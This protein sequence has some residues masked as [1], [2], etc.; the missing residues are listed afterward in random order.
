MQVI[1]ASRKL[2]LAV[3]T[4]V[5]TV[6]LA[7]LEAKIALKMPWWRVPTQTIA[8]WASSMVLIFLPLGAWMLQ[9]RR[10]ALALT[11]HM[12]SL[13]CLL[14]VFLGLNTQ[15]PSLFFFI[16]L[17]VGYWLVMLQWLRLEM[18]R[19]FFNPRTRW[20]EGL[21][22]AIAA[23]KCQLAQGEHRAELQVSRMDLEGAF[24]FSKKKGLGPVDLAQPATLHFSFRDRQV[25][26]EGRPVV[27]LSRNL[28]AGF[29]FRD[30]SMDNKKDLGDFVEILRGEG[31][32]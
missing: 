23:L 14:S 15:N 28:G 16:L 4:L 17:L 7:V 26:C 25:S 3:A 21:P 18:G 24:V 19:S 13:W 10:W 5:L 2:R 20:Y 30:L 29:E 12:A 31:Y 8:I 27:V 1:S 6:P 11:R 9:G 22:K 32:V